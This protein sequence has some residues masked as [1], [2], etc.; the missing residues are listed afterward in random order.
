MQRVA[1]IRDASASKKEGQQKTM[2]QGEM[3]EL[4]SG[5]TQNQEMEKM[6]WFNSK[7]F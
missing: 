3:V 5:K 1:I 2:C 7:V 4:T 6:Y